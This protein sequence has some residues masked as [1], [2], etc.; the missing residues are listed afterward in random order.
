LAVSGSLWAL[1]GLM[2]RGD[3]WETSPPIQI[4][5]T[6]YL[7]QCKPPS[8]T[9]ERRLQDMGMNSERGRVAAAMGN[10]DHPIVSARSR[11]EKVR[12]YRIRAVARWEPTGLYPLRPKVPPV[13]WTPILT[14]CAACGR[15]LLWNGC[16]ETL[17][18]QS[19]AQ[20]LE[21][22]RFERAVYA[23]LRGGRPTGLYPLQPKLLPVSTCYDGCRLAI[24]VRMGVHW[25]LANRCGHGPSDGWELSPRFSLNGRPIS[26]NATRH[27]ERAYDGGRIWV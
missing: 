10:A 25:R 7:S 26:R 24:Y 6:P 17:T 20:G 19:S 9:M 11:G 18:I 15:A 5:W 14:C 21:V 13:H 8:G 16:W 23:P 22:R 27:P 4:E 2:G 12:T 3:G 1:R